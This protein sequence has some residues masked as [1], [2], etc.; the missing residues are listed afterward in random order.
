MKNTFDKLNQYKSLLSKLEGAGA[1]GLANSQRKMLESIS[2]TSGVSAILE[3]Q[4]KKINDLLGINK[5]SSITNQYDNIIKASSF[6]IYSK[7]QLAS[8]FAGLSA[9]SSQHKELLQN[10]DN[11]LLK[12][13][14]KQQAIFQSTIFNNSTIKHFTDEKLRINKLLSNHHRINIAKKF[15]FLNSSLIGSFNDTTRILSELN[16][17]NSLIK[18]LEVSKLQSTI[19][20]SFSIQLLNEL[21]V[22]NFDFNDALEVVEEAFTN[23][24]ETSKKGWISAEGLF[25]L[26]FAIVLYVLSQASAMDSEDA[27]MEK[28]SQLETNFIEQIATLIPDEQEDIIST[29]YIVQRTAKLHTESSTKSHVLGFLYPNQRVRLIKRK[30]KWIYIEYFDNLKGIPKLGWV[31]KKYLR[32]EKNNQAHYAND[33]TQSWD[34]EIEKDI[35][36]GK[37]DDIAN[38]AITDYK[39]GRFKEL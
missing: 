36:S 5:L 37:L 20:S 21:K 33:N 19:E 7:S 25:Q 35:A 2:R 27:L 23:K 18:N 28:L 3:Q 29:Y 24:I 30:S 39:S 34:K 12:K 31:L 22:D 11:P 32:M 38:K 15:L 6:D 26:F 9:L 17:V 16:S 10:I 1:L 13:I 14:E 4:Q 8:S